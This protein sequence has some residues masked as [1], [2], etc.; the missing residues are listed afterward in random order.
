MGAERQ[1]TAGEAAKEKA[2]N[3]AAEQPE[4]GDREKTAA[5]AA[6]EKVERR[7]AEAEAGEQAEQEAEEAEKAVKQ[8][9][10]RTPLEKQEGVAAG[11]IETSNLKETGPD[12][13]KS[14]D[15][16]RE[17]V[18]Q[19]RE[20]LAA[21]VTELSQKVDPRP[22]VEAA[23]ESAKAQANVAAETA[24]S[25]AAPIAFGAGLLLVLLIWLRRR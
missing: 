15:E 11:T 7:E 2:E 19:A 21:T 5:E 10:P 13:G 14:S 18:E 17:E 4:A 20:E 24:R 25:N 3:K 12:A 23:A 9:D 1:K 6:K 22:S 8:E 16:L